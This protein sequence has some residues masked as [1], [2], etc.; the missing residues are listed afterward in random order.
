MQHCRRI[1]LPRQTTKKIFLRPPDFMFQTL[2]TTPLERLISN[3]RNSQS[4]DSTLVLKLPQW[5]HW[6]SVFQDFLQ[7]PLTTTP[8]PHSS[9]PGRSNRS[10]RLCNVQTYEQPTPQ[11]NVRQFILCQCIR[12]V[13]R[14]SAAVGFAGSCHLSN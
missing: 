7:R 3:I 1:S 6:Q 5:K 11:L 4:L 8:C 2:R 12:V 14:V 13:V 9:L 10:R